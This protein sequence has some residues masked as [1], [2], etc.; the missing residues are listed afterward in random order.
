MIFTWPQDSYLVKRAA[1]INRNGIFE[2]FNTNNIITL[3]PLHNGF[4][5]DKSNKHAEKYRYQCSY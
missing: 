1:S 2:T 3:N 5:N 4:E